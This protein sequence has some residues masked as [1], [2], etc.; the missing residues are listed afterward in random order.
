MAFLQGSYFSEALLQDMHFT[1][2]RPFENRTGEEPEKYLILL[3]GLMDNSSAWVLKT[4]L[5]RLAEEYGVTVFC[6][7]GHRSYYCDMKFGGRYRQ[8]I[9]KEIPRVMK[10]MLGCEL[11]AENTVIAG[12]SAGGLGALKAMLSPDSIYRKCMAF[13]PVVHP[14]KALMDIPD[15]YLISGEER[16]IFGAELQVPDEENPEALLKDER[17]RDKFPL[18]ITITCGTE[19]FLLEQNR[20]FRKAFEQAGIPVTYREAAGEHGWEYWEEH[21]KELF[22]EYFSKE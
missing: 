3:H 6:P 17:L 13:S 4:T 7:E 21:L 9:I 15:S 5:Y 19:D 2:I 16:A 18:Q 11:N 14:K 1:C 10:E 22:E 20:T 12:N 8:M